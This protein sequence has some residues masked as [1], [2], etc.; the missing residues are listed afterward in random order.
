MAAGAWIRS[1]QRNE[2]MTSIPTP[3]PA[4]KTDVRPPIDGF[5]V[6]VSPDAF[7]TDAGPSFRSGSYRAAVKDLP[8]PFAIA[9]AN[10]A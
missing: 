7:V 6:A 3:F 8:S 10:R 9:R 2:K 1:S 4:A 5:H